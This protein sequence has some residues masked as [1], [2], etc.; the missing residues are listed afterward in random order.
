MPANGHSVQAMLPRQ[1]LGIQEFREDAKDRN[2][3][4]LPGHQGEERQGCQTACVGSCAS[5]PW[6]KRHL[7]TQEDL[8]RFEG[9]YLPQDPPCILKISYENHP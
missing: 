4:G 7:K 9:K 6:D 8:P 1:Q 5:C 3:K 2:M